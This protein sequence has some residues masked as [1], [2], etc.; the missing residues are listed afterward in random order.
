LCGVDHYQDL[1]M[2]V[3]P[4][5]FKVGDKVQFL[6]GDKYVQGIADAGLYVSHEQNVKMSMGLVRFYPW[7]ALKGIVKGKAVING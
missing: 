6:N 3:G 2:D 5:S 7:E 1:L 4:E